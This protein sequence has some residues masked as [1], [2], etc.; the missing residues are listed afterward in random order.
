MPVAPPTG[1]AVNNGPNLNAFWWND[2]AGVDG[3]VLF[4]SEY[5]SNYSWSVPKSVAKTGTPGGGHTTTL[6]DVPLGTDLICAYTL[7]S[8]VGSPPV[9]SLP[10]LPIY[11]H[12]LGPYQPVTVKNVNPGGL[13]AAFAGANPGDQFVLAAGN[14]TEGNSADVNGPVRITH[15]GVA[16]APVTIIGA[17]RVNVPLIQGAWIVSAP[18]VF[19]TRLEFDGANGTNYNNYPLQLYANHVTIDR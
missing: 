14:Y 19:I 3:F 2:Q 15:G 5:Q 18:Y 13:R 12:G 7:C 10:S 11:T 4:R 9:Y 8:F 17:S 6:F 1:F 16:G